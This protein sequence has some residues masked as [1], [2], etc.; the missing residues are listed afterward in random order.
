MPAIGLSYP[1]QDRG[2][3][4]LATTFVVLGASLFRRLGL[5]KRRVRQTVEAVDHANRGNA[6]VR[7]DDQ[8][9]TVAEF[10]A[11][12]QIEVDDD[13]AEC[14]RGLDLAN[15]GKMEAAV[16]AFRNVIRGQ[17]DD[18][19]GQPGTLDEAVQVFHAANRSHR[20]K[21][22][23]GVVGNPYD[24]EA[25]FNLGSFLLRQGK[26]L[27]AVGAFNEAIRNQ[28]D[29]ALAHYSLGTT[30]AM[31]GRLEQATVEFRAAIRVA[32]D[33]AEAHYNLAHAMFLQGKLEQAIAEFRAAIGSS[34]G[35]AKAHLGLGMVLDRQGKVEEATAEFR[36]AIGI[37]PDVAAPHFQLGVAL[38][39]LGKLEESTSEFHAA[40]RIQPDDAEA[41]F[42]LGL[43]HAVRGHF[44]EAIIA[45]REAIRLE[46]DLAAARYNL[47][48][49]LR[50]NGE[51]D[52][53]VAEFRKA[54]DN[55]Q[56][57]SELAQLIERELSA[58]DNYLGRELFP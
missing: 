38:A 32:P 48:N 3:P 6:M 53:A 39:K 20:L 33:Y 37:Q 19:M 29:Y 52:E 28:P 1:D 23:D 9:G 12:T 4:T 35:Y 2:Q 16:A 17:P 41:H 30:L 24:V 5:D 44:E 8:S 22:L 27:E 43:S 13:D 26:L 58:I 14:H 31:A 10:R 25:Y 47:G 45:Y 18:A 21:Y 40:A 34:P 36:T 15:Q 42:K 7:Q 46:P 51:L 11:P 50:A 55:A 56:R 49:A 54:R 57:G